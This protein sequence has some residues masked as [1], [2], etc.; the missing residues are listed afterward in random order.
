MQRTY[1][2]QHLLLA[3]LKEPNAQVFFAHKVLACNLRRK[4]VTFEDL[5][6]QPQDGKPSKVDNGP[7]VPEDKTSRRKTVTYNFMIGA[8]GAHSAVRQQL[9]RESNID[10]EQSYVDA[11]WC[12]F[13]IAPDH[14][15]HHQL[16]P[17]YLHVWPDKERVFIVQP[18]VGGFSRGGMV[19]PAAEFARLK[20]HPEEIE[21]FFQSSYPGIIPSRMSAASV[22]EQFLRKEHLSLIS[23]KCGQFGYEDS[24]VLL[25]DS[26]HTMPPF[27]GMGMNTGLEDVRIFFEE[28]LDPAHREA[29]TKTFCPK[30]VIQ[31]YTEYRKPDVQSM[32]DIARRH[33]NELKRGIPSR[34]IAARS[35]IESS[36]QKYFPTLDYVPMYSRIVFGHE[37]VSVAQRKDYYQRILFSIVL[38]GLCTVPALALI[39]QMI[40]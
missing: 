31:A 23:I 13:V 21:T 8:D 6:W 7:A 12:D 29:S 26:S 17:A 10:Y 32:T 28:F 11:L 20:E 36:L 19:A 25:G 24:C 5:K 3:L 14:E 27:Y 22:R 16:D 1:I 30:G 34:A 9:M 39:A 35:Q 4:T 2:G 18:D 33:L 37:R 15:G 40:G 38:T